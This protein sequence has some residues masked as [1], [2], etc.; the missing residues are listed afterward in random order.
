MD[1]GIYFGAQSNSI[2][3]ITGTHNPTIA[4]NQTELRGTN[5]WVR[6]FTASKRVSASSLQGLHEYFDANIDV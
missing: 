2:L 1:K 5:D 3:T 4:Y 6:T